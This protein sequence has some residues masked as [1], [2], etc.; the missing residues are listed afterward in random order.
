MNRLSPQGNTKTI[1]SPSFKQEEV[2]LCSLDVA[3]GE[4]LSGFRWLTGAGVMK[5]SLSGIRWSE[6]DFGGRK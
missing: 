5:L 4:V 3:P 1:S 6:L 2:F